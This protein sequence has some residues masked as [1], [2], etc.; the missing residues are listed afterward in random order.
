[1]SCSVFCPIDSRQA[2]ESAAD[3]LET[4]LKI[5][6]QEAFSSLLRCYGI[7]CEHVDETVAEELADSLREG[8]LWPQVKND[9]EVLRPSRAE[10]SL[11]FQVRTNVFRVHRRNGFEDLPRKGLLLIPSGRVVIRRAITPP[12]KQADS[13]RTLSHAGAGT[14]GTTPGEQ[15]EGA[16]LEQVIKQFVDLY[17]MDGEL[18]H[19]RVDRDELAFTKCLNYPPANSAEE[20]FELYLEL[21]RRSFSKTV[22]I[23]ENVFHGVP[24]FDRHSK[25]LLNYEQSH[26]Y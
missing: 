17:V 16:A 14:K 9:E 15:P 13:L 1:M 19:F 23:T 18:R 12:R 20:N 22:N 25:F 3:A 10:H 4:H 24:D 8:D 26:V 5:T 11:G 21:L 6:R 2:L 7:L